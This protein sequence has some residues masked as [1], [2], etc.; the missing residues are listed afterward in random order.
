MADNLLNRKLPYSFEAEQSVL[1]S[2]LI[3][4]NKLNDIQ[5]KLDP[6]DF[7]G[8]NHQA[9]F[10]AMK[11][12]YID[13]KA[14]DPVTLVNQL[15]KDGIYSTDD[16]GTEYLTV[17]ADVVPS[18]ENILDYT[19][20]V[21]D[22]AQLRRLIDACTQSTD[23][24][25]SSQDSVTDI[26]N[27]ASGRIAD[28]ISGAKNQDFKKIKDVLQNVY[29]NLNELKEHPESAR[30]V[31]TG[32]EALDK[33]LV[34][35]Q[36]SDLVFVG[37]R[38]G[39]GKTSFVLNLATT[40]AKNTGKDVAIFSLEMSAEQLVTRILSSEALVDSYAFRTG[41]LTDE[42]WRDIAHAADSLANC[43]LYIDDTPGITVSGMKSKLRKL[44][45]L[46]MVVIDY[47]QLMSCDRK[48]ENRTTEVSDISRNLKLLAKELEVPVIVC[49]QLNRETEKRNGNKPQLSDLRESG[50]LEQ[51]ADMVLFLYRKDYYAK[52]DS[53]NKPIND[54]PS[55]DTA[56]V[57]IA[58]NRHG[59]SGDVEMGWIGKFTKFVSQAKSN[60]PGA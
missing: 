16:E 32:F 9:I 5:G 10:D 46:G 40:C 53:G 59:S 41:N 52:D 51:D 14:I 45:N 17:L 13:S 24:A 6:E 33:V 22:K 3:D 20:I 34:G 60:E 38:P 55:L 2:I 8:E 39:M 43:N 44:K 50:S 19:Q 12:L 37:A 26:I 23:D 35:F 56:T 29:D 58:K 48:T 28:I 7:Y 36:K 11:T 27:A 57:V 54:S 47:L 31:S 4:P 15:V 25:Y 18:A 21:R 49:T 30:G 1:G 42:N